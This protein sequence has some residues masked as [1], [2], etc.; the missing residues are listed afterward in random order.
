M[1]NFNN[2][3]SFVFNTA[4]PGAGDVNGNWTAWLPW[5]PCS[6]TCG[7]GSQSRK[8]TCTNPLPQG[9]GRACL[10]KDQ[11]SRACS[12]HPCNPRE[13]QC[14]FF[15][16]LFFSFFYF[17][18]LFSFPFLY[19]SLSFLHRKLLVYRRMLPFTIKK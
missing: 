11:E 10:G 6:L 14:L 8:R 9:S 17:S 18:F 15:I 13:Y 7:G 12:E 3:L 16:F 2:T 5:S 19:I 1:H 4:S